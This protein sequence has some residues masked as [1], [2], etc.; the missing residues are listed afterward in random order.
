MTIFELISREVT[1]RQA[2]ELYGLKI[3]RSGRGFC[4]WHEDGKHPA[5]QFFD[6][7]RCYCHSCHNGGDATDITAKMLNLSGK[8]AAERIKHDFHL[9]QPVDRRPDPST[10][11]RIKAKQDAKVAFDRRWDELCGIVRWADAELAKYT[12]D[13]ADDT[14]TRILKARTK[15]NEEMDVMWEARKDGEYYVRGKQEG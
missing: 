5:L 8:E 12:P 2:A 11:A 9:D 6:N 14:F 15:A 10:K 13:T 4:P 7:G 1:A 3:D